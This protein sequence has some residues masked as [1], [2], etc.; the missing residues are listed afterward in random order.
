MDWSD[1]RACKTLTPF[2]AGFR[3][4]AGDQ[5]RRS[6]NASIPAHRAVGFVCLLTNGQTGVASFPGFPNRTCDGGLQIRI[7]FPSC[8][9]GVNLGGEEGSDHK[10]HVAYPSM[11]DNGICPPTHPVRIPALLYEM[12]WAVDRFNAF[13]SEEDG[14][15]PFVLSQGDPTGYGYHADFFNGWDVD[16]LGAALRDPTCA[17]ASGGHIDQ[18]ETFR[19]FLQNNTVQNMCLGIEAK[20]KEPMFGVLDAL[21]GC[22]P[23]QSG[24]ENAVT[25]HC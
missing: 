6:Y 20:V 24:P 21:P 1:Y 25:H 8:W 15:Q 19:P 4:I 13:R 11:V 10:S 5:T 23:I 9:D 22:N 3:M 17:N 16:V 14:D 12:T 7:R 2:P 18:C